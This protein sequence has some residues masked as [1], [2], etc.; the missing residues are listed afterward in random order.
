MASFSAELHVSGE[1]FPVTHCAFGVAQA[2]HQRGRVST[3]VR[4]GPVE[5]VLDVPA[6]DT[7]FGWAAAAQKRQPVQVLFRDGAGGRVLETLDL[8][9]A[10]CV[11][12]YEQFRHGDVGGGSYQCYLT[13]SDPDGWTLTAG[14]PAS[15]LVAP[16]ARN[17]GLPGALVAG[18][19]AVSSTF[20]VGGRG[21]TGFGDTK[22]IHSG[23]L[24]DPGTCGGAILKL[25][26][27]TAQITQEG[28]ATVKKHISRFAPVQANRKMV[29]RLEQIA[30]GKL[31]ISDFDKRYYTHELRE[32]E[33]YKALQVPDGTDP[34]YEV[35]NDAHSATLEDYQ[36]NE[37]LLPLYHPDITDEDFES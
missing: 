32:Y 28:I 7:L 35:W 12:Y 22:G 8:K 31:P 11:S 29:A 15:A 6:G 26:W 5:L 30:S 10:Y 33:R 23:R 20:P 24:Y 36:I 34:G 4:F 27:R 16:A 1:S 13:L 14:G 37:R 2:T 9:A 21:P 19:Q 25:D 18:V 17:H 3:K